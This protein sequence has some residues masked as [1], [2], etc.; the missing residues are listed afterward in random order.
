MLEFHDDEGV[1]ARLHALLDRWDQLRAAPPPW[2]RVVAG[3]TTAVL[4]ALIAWRVLRPSE[5][6]VD[7]ADRIPIVGLDVTT[8]TG[9][10]RT[11]LVHVVGAVADPG[12][13]ALPADARIGD[14]LDAAGGPNPAADLGELNLAAPLVD[15]SQIR[16]G[17]VG[18]EPVSVPTGTVGPGGDTAAPGGGGGPIDLNRASAADLETL[19]GIGPAT[20]AKILDWRDSS[21]PFRSVDDLLSVAGIGPAKLEALRDRVVVS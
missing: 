17:R 4:V 10:P 1:S 8:T 21:G 13:V 16:V 12:V 2:A 3:S 19:P 20:A 11:V 14:A 9:P 15:G 5:P 18:D 6:T 7:V